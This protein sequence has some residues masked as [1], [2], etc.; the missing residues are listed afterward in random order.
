MT[1]MSLCPTFL[2]CL[3]LYPKGNNLIAAGVDGTTR[4]FNLGIESAIPTKRGRNSTKGF[5]PQI[6]QAGVQLTDFAK[7][8]S[9]S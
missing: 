4:L 6:T 5:T 2:S 7:E 1:F 8:V 3:T 9:P